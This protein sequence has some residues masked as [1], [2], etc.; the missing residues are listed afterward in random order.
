MQPDPITDLE[1]LPSLWALIGLSA[2]L[3]FG[4]FEDLGLLAAAVLADLLILRRMHAA[5]R[6]L[7]AA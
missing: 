3:Q 1:A 4:M 6:G 5:R 7:R 2:A